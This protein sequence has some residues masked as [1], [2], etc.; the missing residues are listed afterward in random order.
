MAASEVIAATIL[1]ASFLD[2]L[3]ASVWIPSLCPLPSTVSPS[4]WPKTDLVLTASG[5]WWIDTLWGIWLLCTVLPCCFL[6]L[7]CFLGKYS[8]SFKCLVPLAYTNR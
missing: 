6:R 5:L 8:H 3:S 2:N 7:V 1:A 4:Q